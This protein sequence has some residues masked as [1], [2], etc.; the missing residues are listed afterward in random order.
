MKELK[1]SNNMV[2]PKLLTQHRQNYIYPVPL[3]KRSFTK[4]GCLFDV[5]IAE[6]QSSKIF[7]CFSNF[8]VSKSREIANSITHSLAYAKIDAEIYAHNIA[9][10]ILPNK[11][12]IR[13]IGTLPKID[14]HE[15]LK[16]L[17]TAIEQ[18]FEVLR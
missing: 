13:I 9:I 6:G 8:G 10:L 3:I 7:V 18:T 16:R 15:F 4:N 1:R 12:S 5:N 2:N 14:A 11:P 17:Q